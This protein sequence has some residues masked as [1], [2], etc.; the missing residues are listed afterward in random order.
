[1][2]QGILALKVRD[3][4][5]SGEGPS[6][7]TWDHDCPER[8]WIVG[9]RSC[10]P[11]PC[12]PPPGSSWYLGLKS[13]L[14]GSKGP[15]CGLRRAVLGP[16]GGRGGKNC[17]RRWEGCSGPRRALGRLG[18]GRWAWPSGPSLPRLH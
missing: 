15:G 9:G 14:Q 10:N 11:C 12:P 8:C 2:K 17:K 13:T 5:H 1:M 18:Q 4:L 6:D 7:A 3:I 16:A